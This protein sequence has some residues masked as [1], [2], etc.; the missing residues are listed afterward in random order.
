MPSTH[1]SNVLSVV[2]S[3]ASVAVSSVAAASVVDL[4]SSVTAKTLVSE[5]DPDVSLISEI[6]TMNLITFALK[7]NEC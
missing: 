5:T 7:L 4:T 6:V 3:V 2:A 1:P